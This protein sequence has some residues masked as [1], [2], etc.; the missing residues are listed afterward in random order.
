MIQLYKHQQR[1]IDENPDRK[2]LVW[3]VG[4]G[5]SYAACA[6]LDRRRDR[7][8]LIICPKAIV[9]KWGK[10]LRVWN[11]KADIYTRDEIKK[12]DLSPFTAIVVDE[13]HDFAAPLFD[14]G[15][16]ARA[17]ALYKHLR[18]VSNVHILLL[19]ATPVRST[20][21]N[22][23]TLGVYV[24]HAWN[25]RD[26]RNEFF[27]FTKRYNR[28]FYEK[29]LGWQKL[30]RPYV[31]EIA[32]IVLMSDCVDVPTQRHSVV[33]V[34]WGKVE[35]AKYK[36]E[37]SDGYKEPAALWHIRHRIEQGE[38][39]FKKLESILDGYRK[40]IVVCMYLSQIEDYAKR[41]GDSRQVFILHGA[42]KDQHK[43]IEDA[44]AADDCVFIIQASMG[45]G[46][47]AS[48]FSCV[49]F[50]SLSFRYTDLVQMR[51][52]VKRINNLHENTFYYLLGGQCDESVFNTLEQHKDFDVHY[53]L[54][55]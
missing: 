18:A 21:W 28:F 46:F 3:E 38:Q 35:Q 29:K 9:Q 8:A 51:G 4:T 37:S 1:F 19:T 30:I 2:L 15:K 14:K 55:S 27:Q 33:R 24:G 22:I 32:D 52:R 13:A 49:I 42:T 36:K 44:R 7:R 54:K 50:A 47:D 39:K 23:H 12:I 5:K 34:P 10:D 41:L 43:V 17:V 25:L 16:S 11:L 31:E 20:P 53:Q 40:A 48:E 6:W 45:A 26:F